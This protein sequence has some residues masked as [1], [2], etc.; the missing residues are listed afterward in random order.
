MAPDVPSSHWLVLGVAQ[1]PSPR[2]KVDADAAVPLFKFATGRFPVMSV[3]KLMA[4]VL[5]TTCVPLALALHKLLAVSAPTFGSSSA[6]ALP[7]AAMLIQFVPSQNCI[8]A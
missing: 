2:Q 3:V 7:E 4:A 8:V 1:V 6:V 5:H